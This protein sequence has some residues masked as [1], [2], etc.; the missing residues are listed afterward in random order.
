VTATYYRDFTQKLR[1]K[2]HKNQP[3]LLGN[4]PLILHDNAH[5]HLGKVVTDLLSKYEWEVLPHVPYSPG[6]N[7]PDF[8]LFPK[9]KQ[10]TCGQRFS[11][12]EQLPAGVT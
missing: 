6:M 5:P 10:P 1:T 9:L 3:D 7:P 2:M 11:S 8:D 4:G 12:L